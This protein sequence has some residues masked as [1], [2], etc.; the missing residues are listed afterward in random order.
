M[1][2]ANSYA[3]GSDYLAPTTGKEPVLRAGGGLVTGPGTDTNDGID[4]I[5]A[6]L[7]HGEYVA[8]ASA[9]DFY[10]KQFFDAV[11][12]KTYV[13]AAGPL[14]G[15]GMANHRETKN[16]TVNHYGPIIANSTAEYERERARRN[17]L[18][19]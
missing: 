10:G 1:Q 12:A 9:V 11:N 7:S 17:L 19:I 16:R 4:G 15:A 13:P 2:T 6:R 3:T 14:V 5:D 8:R 18:E